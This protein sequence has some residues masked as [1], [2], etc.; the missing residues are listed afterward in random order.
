MNIAVGAVAAQ[1]LQQVERKGVSA[2]VLH[3]AVQTESGCFC[4][5]R[6]LCGTCTQAAFE[7]LAGLQLCGNCKEQ[8]GGS[9]ARD[10]QALRKLVC[11]C[12]QQFFAIC[13]TH[14]PSPCEC[15]TA[16][17]EAITTLGRQA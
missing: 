10:R 17:P 16:P 11:M 12:L 2:D 14:D 3:Q 5:E 8:L 1:H 13:C 7:A 4:R 15:R 9:A 6:G